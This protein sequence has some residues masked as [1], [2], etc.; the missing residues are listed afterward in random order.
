MPSR[1]DYLA[2]T[3]LTRM[4]SLEDALADRADGSSD[5]DGRRLELVEKVLATE[6]GVLD[7]SLHRTIL[8]AMPTTKRGEAV[9]DRDLR[10][11]TAFLAKH[12]PA[13]LAS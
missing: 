5:E 3:L 6:A 10:E 1:F 13:E 8:A 7:G 2:R 9:R 12:L 11:F 4:R